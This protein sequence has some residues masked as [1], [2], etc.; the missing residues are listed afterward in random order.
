MTAYQPHFSHS[1]RWSNQLLGLLC[2]SPSRGGGERS[3]T[4][5]W[6]L[7]LS[8]GLAIKARGLPV[9]ILYDEQ[10]KEI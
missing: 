3:E 6:P 4:E 7:G 5:G 1:T 2:S 8:L 9:T 10:G